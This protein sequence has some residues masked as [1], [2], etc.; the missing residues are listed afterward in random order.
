MKNTR[1]DMQYTLKSKA[2]AVSNA[3]HIYTFR[4]AE[5][6]AG[7][8]NQTLSLLS[9]DCKWKFVFYNMPL[10]PPALTQ[11]D[12]FFNRYS[13]MT[14]SELLANS[15]FVKELKEVY[16][17]IKKDINQTSTIMYHAPNNSMNCKCINSQ[18]P[19]S[20]LSATLLTGDVNLPS[21]HDFGNIGERVNTHEKGI[22]VLQVPH[23]GSKENL[24]FDW[25][26]YNPYYS[27]ISYGIGNQYSHPNF[28]TINKYCGADTI[29]RLVNENEGFSY[30]IVAL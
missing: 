26:N 24:R 14:I 10:D 7:I 12:T 6:E 11:L 13:D 18:W 8:I 9:G 20:D 3:D 30:L 29:L 16:R 27:V 1:Y 23:H 5:I 4:N 21:K 19:P 17:K 28:E 22:A 25:L 2:F 15:V